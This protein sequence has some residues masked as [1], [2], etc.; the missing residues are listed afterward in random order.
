MDFEIISKMTAIE[1]MAMN[2]SIR[3]IAT[4]KLRTKPLVA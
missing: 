3:E 1:T 2:N 4:Q